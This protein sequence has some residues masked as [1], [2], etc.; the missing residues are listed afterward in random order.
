MSPISHVPFIL[1]ILSYF[2]ASIPS[3]TAALSAVLYASLLCHFCL[4]P[5]RSQ[6]VQMLGMPECDVCLAQCV[7]YLARAPKSIAVFEAWG[8][9]KVGLGG[10]GVVSGEGKVGGEKGT[11]GNR[12]Y[13]KRKDGIGKGKERRMMG[14]R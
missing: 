5:S 3:L 13:G 8:R 12:V 11:G 9:V 14:S 7:A 1:P 6:A 10:W 2:H 4:S